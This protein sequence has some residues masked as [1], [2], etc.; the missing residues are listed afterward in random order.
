MSDTKETNEIAEKAKLAE[1]KAPASG[2]SAGSSSGKKKKTAYR[3]MIEHRLKIAAIVVGAVSVLL[4]LFFTCI[5]GYSFSAKAWHVK[6]DPI[7]GYAY[8]YYQ[9][10]DFTPAH[11]VIES[12]SK[13]ATSVTVPDT[14]WGARVEEISDDAF[15]SSVQEIRLGK[16][17]YSVGEGYSDK[18]FVLPVQQEEDRQTH[19][20]CN[21]LKQ[22]AGQH[23]VPPVLH[24]PLR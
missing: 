13:S 21:F 3:R 23:H 1:T 22:S 4:I 12:C 2:K 14:I 18:H 9:K 8:T 24:R 7:H 16:Y 19:C 11:I 17:I 5:A 10:K 15:K 20:A 6:F